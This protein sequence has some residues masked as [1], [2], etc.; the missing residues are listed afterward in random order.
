[1]T[2]RSRA[3]GTIVRVTVLLILLVVLLAGAL[4]ALATGR[5]GGVS[6]A[7]SPT[8]GRSGA[9]V[10]QGAGIAGDEPMT[11]AHMAALRFDRAPRGYR[12]DQVD[13]VLDRLAE[14]L[15]RHQEELARLRRGR[16][17]LD[18]ATSADEWQAPQPSGM[19][20][21]GLPESRS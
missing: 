17:D 1:M 5:L 14:E 12:M 21:S 20:T 4:A 13:A 19:T 6:V 16:E 3:R 2:R 10:L 18:G 11:G 7:M 8:P 9:D 15:A